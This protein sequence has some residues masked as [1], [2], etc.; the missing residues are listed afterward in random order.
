MSAP[1]AQ[2]RPSAERRPPAAHGTLCSPRALVQDPH[3]TQSQ[4]LYLLYL[5]AHDTAELDVATEQG[6][7]G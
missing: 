7:P 2:P 6:M 4:K 3:L 1:H 5:W